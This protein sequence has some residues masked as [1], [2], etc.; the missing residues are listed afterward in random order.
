MASEGEVPFADADGE[1]KDASI[2]G[3]PETR[4]IFIKQVAG[5]SA[6]IA[7]GPNLLGAASLDQAEQTSGATEGSSLVKV[8]R[9]INGKG[10]ALALTVDRA[11]V[12]LTRSSAS[13]RRG[14][15]T[16]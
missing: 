14:H 6:A 8:N 15:R 7:I 9:K 12:A 3:Q 2:L 13:A 1:L 5:T 10:Y 4:R 11:I 16:S